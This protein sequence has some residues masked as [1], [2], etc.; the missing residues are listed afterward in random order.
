MFE[1]PVVGISDTK[2]D[3]TMEVGGYENVTVLRNIKVVDG[4][5][6]DVL[7]QLPRGSVRGDCIHFEHKSLVFCKLCS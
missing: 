2:N 1:Y 7:Q 5:L 6:V 4:D 3:L